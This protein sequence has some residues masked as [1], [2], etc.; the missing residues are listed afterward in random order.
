MIL[1]Q[2]IVTSEITKQRFSDYACN[3]FSLLPSRKSVKK[4]I[5]RGE[6]LLNGNKSSTGE[7]IK[8]GD[9][10]ELID[11][12]LKAPKEY[13][14]SLSIEYEDEFM[15][16]I[17][18]PSGISVSGN[19]FRTIENSL[20][21]NLSSSKEPDAMK[22]PKPVHRLDNP[23]SGLLLIAKTKKARITLGQLFENKQIQKT[24]HAI[25]MGQ[26]PEKGKIDFFIEDKPAIT[27]FE[28]IT[29]VHSLKNQFLT[30]LK[31]SPLTGRTHQI[32]IHCSQSGFPILGDKLYG[33]EG[34]ILKGKG[35]FLV[36]SRLQ[37][38]H[39]I[40]MAPM[41]LSLEI[42]YNFSKRLQNEEL[43]WTKYHS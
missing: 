30:L 29:E 34:N 4:A 38:P 43:R 2:H 28:K 17:N 39:P 24:Y 14:L 9:L 32:R 33:E 40:T 35:L 16:I 36:A 12:E 18:K 37:F 5:L 10:L 22:W 20:P 42:P 41:D 27:Y 7:W 26:T 19:Q 31:L 11:L 13:N 8:K 6:L 21:H 1:E 15:A 25:V 23:T 3:K